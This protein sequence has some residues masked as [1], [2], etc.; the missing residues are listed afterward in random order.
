[1]AGRVIFFEIL[2]KSLQA[3]TPPLDF[4][5]SG[6][7]FL[8][9]S[10]FFSKSTPPQIQKNRAGKAEK[11]T[12]IPLEKHILDPKILI[13]FRAGK[14]G[15]KKLRNSLRKSHFGTPKSP[16]KI[17]FTLEDVWEEDFWF[18]FFEND[19]RPGYIFENFAQICSFRVIFLNFF[20]KSG[21][22][23]LYF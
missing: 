4:D 5:R 8:K 21:P 14:A 17:A 1:M 6:Y 12:K 7:I 22:F 13:F 20:L 23:W 10:E 11:L 19:S 2:W 3:E 16:S 9:S 18:I 15:Q